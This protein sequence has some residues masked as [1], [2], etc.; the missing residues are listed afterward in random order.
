MHVYFRGPVDFGLINIDIQPV[1]CVRNTDSER[2]KELIIKDIISVSSNGAHLCLSG[3]RL[4][5]NCGY[6]AALNGFTSDGEYFRDNIF[7]VNLRNMAGDSGGP[8]FYYK[9]FTYVSLNGIL[10]GGLDDFDDDINDITG[11][12]TISSILNVFEEP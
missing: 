12:T 3:L 10:Q 2:Y 11:V 4:H 9:K 8:I 6:V 7:V 5:V 1:P